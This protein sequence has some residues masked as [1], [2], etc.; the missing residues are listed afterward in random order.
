[1]RLAPDRA[2]VR[3]V[4]GEVESAE[5]LP[6]IDPI[7]IISVLE[8]AAESCF[9]MKLMSENLSDRDWEAIDREKAKA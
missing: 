7:Q 1:M 8:T 6:K 3:Q 9:G 4:F 2:L 5:N